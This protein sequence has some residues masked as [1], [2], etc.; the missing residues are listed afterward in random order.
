VWSD[1]REHLVTYL[2]TVYDQTAGSAAAGAVNGLNPAE[3]QASLDMFQAAAMADMLA[4][5][6]PLA[7]A[8]AALAERLARVAAP[9]LKDEL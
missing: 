8:D 5:R 9:S 7:P 3:E 6:T 1:L 2:T 4:D